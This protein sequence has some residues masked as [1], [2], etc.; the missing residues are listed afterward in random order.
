V[1]ARVIQTVLGA[2]APEQL[3][4][5]MSHVHLTLDILCWYMPP[6]D[7]ALRALAEKP[8][9]LE[10][11][12]MARRNGLSVRDNLLQ[13]DLDLTVRELGEYRRAGGATI[14]DMEMPGIG[15]D[16]GALQRIARATGV[17][18][19]ASTGWY[20]ASSHPA[21]IAA[22]DVG[23]LADEIVREM[24]VG[25][26]DTGVRAGNIAE[27]GLSGYPQDP[28]QPAEEKVLRAAAR[29]QAC[30]GASL[31]IHPNAGI[32][33][34]KEAPADHLDTYIDVIERE[35]ADL[36]KLYISHMGFFPAATA[37]RVLGRGVGFVAYD[38]FGHEEYYEALGPGR[39]FPRDKEEVSLVLALLDAGLVERVL[40]GCEVGWKTC[41]KAYGGWGYAHVLDHIVPWLKDCGATN[42][43]VRTILVDNPARLHA[44][45]PRG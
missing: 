31:T 28:F 33:G 34:L 29:A 5:T 40:I 43:D 9:G 36:E 45:A 19:I 4:I 26:G 15:R 27:I 1:S 6:Q 38:H 22:R 8:L 16:V 14:V 3:G 42:A 18:I 2:V 23:E 11:L 21:D 35:G 24:T 39:A 20:T 41:Y 12:S 10:N 37:K 17:N 30:T 25:I 32:H 7:P 44:L 13:H